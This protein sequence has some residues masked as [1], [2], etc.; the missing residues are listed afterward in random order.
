VGASHG[1]ADC[2]GYESA[3]YTPGKN[4]A[5]WEP[6]IDQLTVMVINQHITPDKK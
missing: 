5:T 1:S 2:Y 6:T 4:I 3:H